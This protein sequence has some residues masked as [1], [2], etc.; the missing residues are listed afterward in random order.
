V[1]EVLIERSAERDLKAL[2]TPFFQRIA[3]RIRA[4]AEIRAHLAATS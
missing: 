3:S 4:L 1:Y 2:P